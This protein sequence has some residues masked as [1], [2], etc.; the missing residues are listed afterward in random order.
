MN[1]KSAYNGQQIRNKRK[2]CFG[3][4][5]RNELTDYLIKFYTWSKK[6]QEDRNLK[7]FSK[8]TVNAAIQTPGAVPKL[9][10]YLLDNMRLEFI[11]TGRIQSDFLESRFGWYRSVV[12]CQY[13]IAVP[14][15]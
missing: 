4:E 15:G 6:C 9:L 13:C 14:S 3:D 5:N 10:N 1:V 8:P 11:L 2:K 12:R 7:G